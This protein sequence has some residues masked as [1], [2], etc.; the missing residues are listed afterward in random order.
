MESTAIISLLLSIVS[1][2]NTVSTNGESAFF[3][4]KKAQAPKIKG[5]YWTA[6]TAGNKEKRE[7]LIQLI[8]N[9]ELNAV[10]IDVKDSTGRV[11]F[12]TKVPLAEMVKSENVRV[13]PDLNELLARLKKDNIYAIARIAV[14]QDPYLAEQLSEISLKKKDGGIWRDHKGL[15]W[16]DPSSLWVWKYNLDI[17]KAA[18]KLGFDE[19]N[20]DYIRFP[21]DGEISDIQYRL[22]ENKITKNYIIANFFKYI[23]K[24]IKWYEARTSIDVFGMT[25]WANNGLGIG[26]RYEDALNSVDFISPM[27][28]PS[29][30]Y[31]NFEGYANPADYPYDIVYKSL[32]KGQG[33][34]NGAR[35]SL[36]PWLQDFDLG[37]IYDKDKI[38][39]QIQATYDAGGWGWMLWNASNNYTKDALLAQ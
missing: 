11:F 30:Y 8:K 4:M 10:I 2:Y 26:Q 20:F 23:E 21:S 28:Y 35:A 36:R 39:K 37:A 18:I 9:T 38:R 7:N 32:M 6:N 22:D 3:A 12:K 33:K 1:A 31:K 15:A 16:V 19:I 34:F 25:F 27:V 14:F 13:A 17:A 5:I 29:H 24:E